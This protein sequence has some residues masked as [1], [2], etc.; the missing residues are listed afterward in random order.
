[1]SSKATSEVRECDI[2][3]PYPTPGCHSDSREQVFDRL[4]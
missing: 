2:F 1:M 3:E 4:S